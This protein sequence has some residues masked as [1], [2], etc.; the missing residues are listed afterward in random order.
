MPTSSNPA[1]PPAY[2]TRREAAKMLRVSLPT[3]KARCKDR[4]LKPVR[5]GRRVLFKYNDIF[6]LAYEGGEK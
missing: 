6:S 5:F 2:L 1:I 3:I 4:T